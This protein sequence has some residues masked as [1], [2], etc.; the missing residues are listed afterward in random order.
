MSKMK[1]NPRK[2]AIF[3]KR[4]KFL[5][6]YLS[7]KGIECDQ[8]K[9][10]SIKNMS[11]PR[12]KRQMQAL[13]GGLN[14]FRTMVPHFGEKTKSLT[15]TLCGPKFKMTAEASQDFAKLK[16]DLSNPPI[17][18]YPILEEEIVLFTDSSIYCIGGSIGHM[19][20][21]QFHPIAYGSKILNKAEIQYPTFKRELLALK[22]FITLWRYYTIGAKFTC[23]IDHKSITSEKFLKKTN[24]KVLINWILKLEEY[25]FD[26]KYLAGKDLNLP[27]CLSRL[28]ATSDKL[29]KWW[30]ENFG[31][32]KGEPERSVVGVV[33]EESL[34]ML[35]REESL[36]L[37]QKKD[38]T[39][40]EVGKWL[41]E[42]K[43]PSKKSAHDFLKTKKEYWNKFESLKLNEED[44]IC[45]QWFDKNKQSYRDLICIP[46]GSVKELLKL[47]HDHVMSGHLAFDKTLER[48]R[49]TYWWP[50]MYGIVELYCKTCDVC[51]KGNLDY[52]KKPKSELQP[53]S[54]NV[55]NG[56]V[57]L[58]LVGPLTEKK[59]AYRWI[60]VMICKFTRLVRAKPLIKATSENIAKAFLNDWCAIY[61]VPNEVMTDMGSNIS[62]SN[63]I[64][65]FY[66]LL[67]INKL[68]TA[69]FRPNCNG[70]VENMNRT[71]KGVLRKFVA[72]FPS[73]W[74]QKLPLVVFAIN[75]SKNATT[76]F[77]PFYLNHSRE[78]RLPS[79]LVF[80]T[81]NTAYYLSEAHLANK[82]YWEMCKVWEFAAKNIADGQ[83][84]QK[85]I[86]DRNANSTKYA[87]NDRVLIYKPLGKGREYNKFKY[88]WDEGWIITRILGAFTYEVKHTSG[89]I[90]VISFDNM[91]LVPANLRFSGKQDEDTVEMEDKDIAD[92]EEITSIID[93]DDDEDK[94]NL[95]LRITRSL[96]KANKISEATVGAESAEFE[97]VIKNDSLRDSVSENDSL[98][99]IVSEDD[100]LSDIIIENDNK[101]GAPDKN[102]EGSRSRDAE[103]V[104]TDQ[105]VDE[106]V[107]GEVMSDTKTEGDRNMDCGKCQEK[108]KET[109]R[110]VERL[111]KEKK[112]TRSGRTTV[113]P[114]RYGV[115]N[116]G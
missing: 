83:I 11:D 109:S 88:K 103:L 100:S 15:N 21:N 49:E 25:D 76:G 9:V 63:F 56:C 89:K 3:K 7:G 52:K 10:A 97:E 59:N 18:I 112:K 79:D 58:D 51:F 1:L 93:S 12:T 44:M 4:I 69:Y 37:L 110:R 54:S 46:E 71:L 41:K 78:A 8:E 19:I 42:E 5:G 27:D 87:V 85:T 80:G 101:N 14:W 47:S 82:N 35:Q 43:K 70:L 91:R 73:S 72:D 17:L 23:Y 113:K 2:C 20:K 94:Q 45:F 102:G 13:L 114:K 34:K 90:K 65:D 38:S 105:N 61:G 81:K 68:R 16:E 108:R 40:E 99:D 48:I 60:L 84:R 6:L 26:I 106:N 115:S 75:T 116:E 104:N 57:A 29:F 96:S 111:D 28:P 53:F 95:W 74:Y 30:E 24:C 77:T 55:V 33:R 31:S 67:S 62:E 98:S 22:H 66:N 32:Q 86:Y 64:R 50:G 36:K 107:Q 92:D 39:L